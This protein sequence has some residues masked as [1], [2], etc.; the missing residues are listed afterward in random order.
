MDPKKW[1]ISVGKKKSTSHMTTHMMTHHRELH[2]A[3]IL[4]KSQAAG[5][6]GSILKFAKPTGGQNA[7]KDREDRQLYSWC[8]HIVM[9]LAPLNTSESP[10]LRLLLDE[11]AKTP[12]HIVHFSTERIRAKLIE[13]AGEVLIG[14]KQMLNGQTIAITTDCWTSGSV[15]LNLV[16]F[17]MKNSGQSI[18]HFVD[19]TLD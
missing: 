1:E 2:D 4:V 9:E 11:V 14:V 7:S 19:C 17:F 15:I 6:K 10:T 5:R 13:L 8:K 18:L 3:D 12:H 16:R